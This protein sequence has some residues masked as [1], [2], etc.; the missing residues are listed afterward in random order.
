[1]K[2]AVVSERRK[3]IVGII[4][5][6]IVAVVMS[7]VLDALL[8]NDIQ[9]ANARF[10][11]KGFAALPGALVFSFLATALPEEV[12]F[13]GFIGQHLSKR[14][15]F[16]AGN[17]IQALLFGLLH[18]AMLFSALGLWLSLVV[19]AFTGTLGWIMGYVNKKADG[20]ILPS[21]IIHGISNIYASLIVMF[22]L[23]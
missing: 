22:S 7:P 2:K 15:G 10:A 12:L 9:L 16:A 8:P 11:G 18:G 1:L 23:W 19:V 20:S 14:I 17:T 5:V 6:L 13:R 4:A 3:F 21:V